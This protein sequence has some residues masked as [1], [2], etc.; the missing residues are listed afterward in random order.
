VDRVEGISPSVDGLAVPSLPD[1]YVSFDAGHE[2]DP[3]E[4]D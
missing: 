3:K 1:D 4:G 2:I